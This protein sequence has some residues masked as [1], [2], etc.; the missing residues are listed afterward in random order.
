M[1]KLI[2]LISII[3]LFAF[4]PEQNTEYSYKGSITGKVMNIDGMRYLIMSSNRGYTSPAVVN[5]TKDKLE[6]EYYSK[7]LTTIH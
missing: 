2:L 1:K 6:C 3:A 5:L 7:E 4:T